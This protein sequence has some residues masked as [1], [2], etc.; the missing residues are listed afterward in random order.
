MDEFVKVKPSAED[1]QHSMRQ[2]QAIY[3]D[4]TKYDDL[5]KHK[6]GIGVIYISAELTRLSADIVALGYSIQQKCPFS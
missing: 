5:F 4:I 6:S 1:C 2:M 3:V